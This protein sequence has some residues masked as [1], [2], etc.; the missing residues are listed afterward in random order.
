MHPWDKIQLAEV[1]QN[2]GCVLGASC[3]LVYK[4]PGKEM[5][6]RPQWVAGSGLCIPGWPSGD[7]AAVRCSS[8]GEGHD[9]WT[10]QGGSH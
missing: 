5:D 8:H 3:R 7:E 10:F 6:G 1:L 9:T 4:D 2:L